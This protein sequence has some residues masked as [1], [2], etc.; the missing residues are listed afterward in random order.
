MGDPKNFWSI[1]SIP[2]LGFLPGNQIAW[3]PKPIP[4]CLF[5][6]WQDP[7]SP[8]KG[9]GEIHI[10]HRH[11][12]WLLQMRAR[13]RNPNITVAEVIW[14]KL[15]QAGSLYE[16]ETDN[17]FKLSLTVSPSTLLVMNYVE[18]ERIFSVTTIYAHPRQLDGRMI[19]R[20]VGAKC[21]PGATSFAHCPA[22]TWGRFSLVPPGTAPI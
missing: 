11:K 5:E 16:T 2:Y 18:T 15:Q 12:P 22:E 21:R 19:C 10:S 9:W 17:K 20:Y 7:G 13:C 14:R 1:N 3:L 8:Q 6:G 4:I